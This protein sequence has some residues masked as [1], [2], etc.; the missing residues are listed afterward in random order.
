MSKIYQQIR[1]LHSDAINAKGMS[2]NEVMKY[3]REYEDTKKAFYTYV[4]EGDGVIYALGKG[5]D[6]RAKVF[7]AKETDLGAN[8]HIKGGIGALINI[9]SKEVN[10]IFI[11]TADGHEAL[12]IEEQLKQIF[13]FHEKSVKDVSK[14]LFDRRL[15]Q[16]QKELP[17]SIYTEY[18]VENKALTDVVFEFLMDPSGNDYQTLKKIVY[19]LD[20]KNPGMIKALNKFFEGGFKKI[21]VPVENP[22]QLSLFELYKAI[23]N[24]K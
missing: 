13:N 18:Y 21:P 9:V 23:I 19:K 4:I 16:L 12:E 2:H 6:N 3:C 1:K 8:G 14:E 17:S 20:K 24:K 22:N 5:T 10:R 7:S 15:A 11:P